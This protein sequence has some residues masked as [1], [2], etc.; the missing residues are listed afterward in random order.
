LKNERRGRLVKRKTGLALGIELMPNTLGTR[1]TTLLLD[2]IGTDI[3]MMTIGIVAICV[4]LTTGMTVTVIHLVGTMIAVL[5]VRMMIGIGITVV[6]GVE[7]GIITEGI[8][9]TAVIET[10]SGSGIE[11]AIMIAIDHAVLQL[12]HAHHLPPHP[13]PAAAPAL[14]HRRQVPLLCPT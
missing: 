14:P 9:H 8:H 2:G 3:G 5:S 11:T 12:I 10:G 4:E 13:P 1:T 7:T 6:I